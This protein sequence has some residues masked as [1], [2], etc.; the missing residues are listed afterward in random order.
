MDCYV[1]NPKPKNVFVVHCPSYKKEG[2]NK[3][4]H[5]FTYLWKENAGI[6]ENQH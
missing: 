4:T 2:R 3:K 5:G 6:P 1:K